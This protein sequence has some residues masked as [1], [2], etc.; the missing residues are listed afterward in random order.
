MVT[1]N[2]LPAADAGP[3]QTIPF[4]SSTTLGPPT[5]IGNTYSWSPSTGLSSST[6]PQPTATLFATTTFTLTETDIVTGCVNSNTVTITVLA[7]EFF[8][9]FSPNGDGVND[10]WNIP[11]LVLYPENSML[12]INRWGDEVWTANNYNNTDVVF[13]GQNM[14]GDNLPDGVYWYILHYNNLEQQGWVFIKR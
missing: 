12:I 10:V 11:L 3:D 8:T 1:V 6:D 5:A 2:P 7:A 14:K 4:G 9:G 13:K